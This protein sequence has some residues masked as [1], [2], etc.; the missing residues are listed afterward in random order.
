M[1][2]ITTM[3]WNGKNR[4]IFEDFFNECENLSH[5]TSLQDLLDDEPEKSEMDC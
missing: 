4:R 2:M 5:L 1:S 3:I